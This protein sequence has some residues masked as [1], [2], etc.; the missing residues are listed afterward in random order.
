M[1]F[2]CGENAGAMVVRDTALERSCRLSCFAADASLEGSL[3]INAEF[4]FV[5]T[6]SIV[7][8]AGDWNDWTPCA[9]PLTAHNGVSEHSLFVLTTKVPVGYHEYLFIVDGVPQLSRGHPINSSASAH[10]RY[11]SGAHAGSARRARV[12][13]ALPKF[14]RALAHAIFGLVCGKPSLAQDS[15]DNVQTAKLHKVTAQCSAALPVLVL[16]WALVWAFTVAVA[17]R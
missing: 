6:A 3:H 8:L 1:G 17:L 14:S 11:V 7:A 4:A 5:G 2:G 16:V 10:W 12:S 13:T 15:F 9:M